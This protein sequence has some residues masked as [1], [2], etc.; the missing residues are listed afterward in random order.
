MIMTEIEI[1][2]HKVTKS[3]DNLFNYFNIQL[4]QFF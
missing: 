2:S 1:Y 3:K 4:L